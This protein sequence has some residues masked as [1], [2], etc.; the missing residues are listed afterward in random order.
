MSIKNGSGVAPVCRALTMHG[1]EI[2]PG[3]YWAR[4]AS[5]PG[6][7]ALWDMA[8][9]EI[10]AGIY[11]LD[12]VGRRP[13]ES[14]YGTVKMWA[15]LQRQGIEVAKCTVERLKREHGWRGVTRA[16]RPRAPSPEE[17]RAE[18]RGRDLVTG[19]HKTI[20]ISAEE[21]Q[22]SPNPSAPS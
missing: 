1:I 4:L 9:T 21:V 14:M 13:P 16:R 12:D 20:V 2:A 3:M 22:R 7:R 17:P 18:I 15:H 11:E 5:G 8:V 6:K 19:L 10:L